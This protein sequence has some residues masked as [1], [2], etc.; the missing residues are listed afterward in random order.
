MKTKRIAPPGYY[1]A[2][3]SADLLGIH[4]DTFYS[5]IRSQRIHVNK[6]QVGGREGFYPAKE[7]DLI[8]RYRVLGIHSYEPW[9]PIFRRAA[10]IDDLR[11]IVDLC[12]PIYGKSGTP[13]L[14]HRIGLWRR[15]PEIYY[16]VVQSGLVIGYIS[17]TWLREDLRR[18]FMEPS[19]QPRSE[20][21]ATLNE[22][23]TIHR[24]SPGMPI[25]HLFVST[26]VHC[27]L[28]TPEKRDCGRIIFSHTID[29]LCGYAKRGMPV[30]TLIACS[31][32]EDG[33]RAARKMQM[34][35]ISYP[36]DPELRF[37]LDLTTSKAKILQPYRDALK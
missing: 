12:V 35:E 27:S 33:I 28:K 5:R 31:S 4:I 15:N 11:G 32:R 2:Q 22:P 19:G 26:S 7:I 37:E 10:S 21:L 16:V 1:T 34:K 8:A 14:K 23:E 18:A 6:L 30:R 25:D 9:S 17:M 20:I 13:T 36:G 3:Q 24:F 29:V